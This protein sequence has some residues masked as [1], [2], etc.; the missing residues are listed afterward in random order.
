M[1]E[2]QS[3]CRI[4]LGKT[5]GRGVMGRPRSRWETNIKT[6]LK[7]KTRLGQRSLGLAM[8]ACCEQD[9]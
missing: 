8:V 6:K 2:T 7:N 3:A 1:G 9:N 4:L 5:K